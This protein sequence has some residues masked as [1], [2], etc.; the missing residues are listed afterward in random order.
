MSSIYAPPDDARIGRSPAAPLYQIH[1]P[2]RAPPRANTPER[3][4]ERQV[5]HVRP[6]PRPPSAH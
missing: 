2:P 1:E 4:R 3:I 5:K 6:R